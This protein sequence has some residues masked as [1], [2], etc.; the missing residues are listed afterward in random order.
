MLLSI[1]K[2]IFDDDEIM[3]PTRVPPRSSLLV[4]FC[5]F[6]VH[7]QSKPCVLCLETVSGTPNTQNFPKQAATPLRRE[8][9]TPLGFTKGNRVNADVVS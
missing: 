5:S 2:V 7:P 3:P 4:I 1:R 8:H 6:T 9:D